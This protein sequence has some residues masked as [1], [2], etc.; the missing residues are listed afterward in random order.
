MMVT[1]D[2]V[3]KCQVD[4]ADVVNELTTLRYLHAGLHHLYENV[5]VEEKALREPDE[6]QGLWRVAMTGCAA[7]WGLSYNVE[8][9][10]SSPI[11][12][13]FD[14]GLTN[15]GE[16]QN[17]AQAHCDKFDKFGK[18]AVPQGGET[19][20]WGLRNMSFRCEHRS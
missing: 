14:P 6:K 17:I 19:G 4:P 10:S 12:I 7:V 20:P 15:M 3:T 11:T 9:A 8:F 1:I 5:V 2:H 16:V 18:D 13:N